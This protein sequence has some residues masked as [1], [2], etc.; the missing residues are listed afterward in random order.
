ML[1][2]LRPWNGC[3]KTVWGGVVSEGL[4]NVHVQIDVARTE[5]EAPPQLK[6]VLAQPTLPVPSGTGSG[7]C[8]RIVT[9]KEMDKRSGSQTCRTIRQS[10]LVH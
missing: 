8:Y 5:D 2:Q 4:A 1:R 6:R 10:L 9:A 7:A 3:Q